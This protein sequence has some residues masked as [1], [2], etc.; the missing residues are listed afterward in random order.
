MFMFPPLS[1]HVYV[2]NKKYMFFSNW[3]IFQY[4]FFLFLVEDKAKRG[5]SMKPK[6]FLVSLTIIFLA[7]LI[8]TDNVHGYG[9]GYKKNYDN[10]LPE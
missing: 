3:K 10:K 2:S 8:I 9:W 1:V 6:K 5:F 7:F 4:I